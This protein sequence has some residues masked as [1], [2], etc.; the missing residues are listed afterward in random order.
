M[1]KIHVSS[2]RD[3]IPWAI[4]EVR[5]LRGKRANAGQRNRG[6]ILKG[7]IDLSRSVRSVGDA[8]GFFSV[9]NDM[10]RFVLRYSVEN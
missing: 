1:N 2:S 8:K 7:R 5:R 9:R 10:V 4:K 6:Q 3:S